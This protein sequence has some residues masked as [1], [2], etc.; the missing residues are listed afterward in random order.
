MVEEPGSIFAAKIQKQTDV[1]K[2]KTND[3]FK[4]FS[5]MRGCGVCVSTQPLLYVSHALDSLLR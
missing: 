2:E 1:E 4:K 3:G 5:L